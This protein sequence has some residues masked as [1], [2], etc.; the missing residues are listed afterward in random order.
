MKIMDFVREMKGK[1]TKEL[2]EIAGEG[3]CV[4]RTYTFKVG[5]SEITTIRGGGIEK[6]GLVKRQK[7][8]RARLSKCRGDSVEEL[9]E[10]FLN[11]GGKGLG[12][13]CLGGLDGEKVY[14][15]R[16]AC[17]NYVQK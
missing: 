4:E 7:S 1:A 17:G 3:N 5:H 12:H 15:R 14:F 11:F 2:L 13:F 16:D 10:S 6:A 8:I 9:I